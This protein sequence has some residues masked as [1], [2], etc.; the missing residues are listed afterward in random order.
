MKK[1]LLLRGQEGHEL[2]VSLCS[3]HSIIKGRE[4]QARHK[5]S[6]TSIA[7]IPIARLPW[8]IRTRF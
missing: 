2:L 6:K 5:Y 3:D 8:L 4:A 7:R 1:V